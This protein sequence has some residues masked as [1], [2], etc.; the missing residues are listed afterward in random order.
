MKAA[1]LGVHL[2]LDRANET[3]VVH[4]LT[5][6]PAAEEETTYPRDF[7]TEAVI[8]RTQRGSAAEEEDTSA[9]DIFL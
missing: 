6:K 4:T 7:D 9:A 8:S 2:I 5:T 3:T 1:H